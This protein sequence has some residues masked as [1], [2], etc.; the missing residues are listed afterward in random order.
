[1]VVAEVLTGISLVKASVDFIKQNINTINDIGDIAKHIDGLFDGEQEI[2]KKRTKAG[3]DPF[4]VHSVAEETIN[5]KLA[6]EQMQEMRNLIDSRFGHGTWAGIIN[7]RARRIQ[8]QK[9]IERKQKIEKNRKAH[10]IAQM[11]RYG[12]A[13]STGIIIF[14][15][16]IVAVFSG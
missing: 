15:C 8:E 5:A 16:I 1:M 9:E 7:E 2:Q 11:M 10:E 6:Q 12:G 3:K 4:S 14:V 13:I